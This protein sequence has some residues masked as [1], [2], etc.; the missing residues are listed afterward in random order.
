MSLK[1]GLPSSFEE[2]GFFNLVDEGEYKCRG[3]I[4]ALLTLD[5]EE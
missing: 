4:S 2:G 5:F 3:C 1:F